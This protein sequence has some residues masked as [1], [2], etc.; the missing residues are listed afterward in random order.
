MVT[1]VYNEAGDLTGFS[2]ILRDVTEQK[3]TEE[4]IRQ[5]TEELEQRVRERT[6]Q[7]EL[8]NKEL[9]SFTH[10]VSHDLR[11]PLRNLTKFSQILLSR[12]HE[13]LDEES[14]VYLTY[15]LESSQQA[16]QLATALLDLSRVTSVPLGKR[17]V[18]FSLIAE[19]IAAE[20]QE[21]ESKRD[22][23]FNIAKD[24]TGY[25]DPVLMKVA[26]QNLLENAWKFTSKEPEALIE[27]G[28][29]ERE[30]RA[31]EAGQHLT[32]LLADWHRTE[33]TLRPFRG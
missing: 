6:D 4:Q 31:D 2:K 12:Q 10:S 16:L 17:S 23:T 25:G 22:V 26:L 11:A 28:A 9:E 33:V 15:I 30:A 32:K 7:L 18:D 20:L 24:L 19:E 13:R 3:Q 5:L 8:V 1:P 14:R 27:F 29:V 21:N